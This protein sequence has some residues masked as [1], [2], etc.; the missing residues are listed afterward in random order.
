MLSIESVDQRYVVSGQ[1]FMECDKDF[2][3]T[4]N[5]KRTCEASGG[6]SWQTVLVVEMKNQFLAPKKILPANSLC[7][8]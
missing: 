5:A 6:Q 8:R 2:A 4:E 7:R 3:V 1:S